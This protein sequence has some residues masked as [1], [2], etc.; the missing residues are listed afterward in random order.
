MID[1]WSGKFGNAACGN[2]VG[3]VSLLD[4]YLLFREDVQALS[5]QDLEGLE[6]PVGGT[7]R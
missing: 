3:G 4:A 1:P 6:M 5:Q 2:F 7:V